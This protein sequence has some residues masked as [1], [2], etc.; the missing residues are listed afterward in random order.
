MKS[1]ELYDKLTL[2]FDPALFIYKSVGGNF[3]INEHE[4]GSSINAVNIHYQGQLLSIDNKF[5][6]NSHDIY[7]DNT[8]RHPY[9]ELK[10]DCDGILIISVREQKYIILLELKSTYSK[11]NIR[12]AEKQLVASYMRL[13]SRLNCLD[14]FDINSYK[15][16]AIIISHQLDPNELLK[17]SRK[18]KISGI[19]SR[20]E[21]QA[22]IHHAN[23]N[24][25]SYEMDKIY[26]QLCQLPI[27]KELYFDYL[28][29]FHGKINN[30]C[31]SGD[32]N[33]ENFLRKI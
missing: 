20:Y 1:N 13:V 30:D 32:I 33:I 21:K 8:S 27:K 9:P 24:I 16:C 25:K 4:S 23:K 28:P 14:N 22:L 11:T 31:N 29:I 5:L 18:K 17:I 26:S 7:P 6:K 19:L 3:I 15:K 10:H 2:V 12:K